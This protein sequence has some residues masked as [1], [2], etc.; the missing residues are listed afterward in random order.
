MVES[1]LSNS[2][3]KLILTWISKYNW[4]IRREEDGFRNIFQKVFVI[5]FFFHKK[6][7]GVKQ[8]NYYSYGIR[9]RIGEIRGMTGATGKGRDTRMRA[10]HRQKNKQCRWSRVSKNVI[11]MRLV[12][13]QTFIVFCITGRQRTQ[14]WKHI[15]FETKLIHLTSTNLKILLQKLKE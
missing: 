13:E 14:L 2:K 3:W 9:P 12:T 1:I 5:Y 4:N 6:H 11:M 8:S 7:T 15:P 10:M